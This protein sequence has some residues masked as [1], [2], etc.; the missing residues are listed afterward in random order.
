[1]SFSPETLYFVFLAVIA[2][3]VGYRVIRYGGFRA[4][5][6]GARI[7]RTVGEISGEKKVL[8]KFVL[9]VYVLR[10]DPSAKLVGV[11]L[12]AKSFASY[13]PMRVTL[14]LNQAEQLASMLQNAVRTY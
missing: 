10:R 11:E 8:M 1:M 14:S 7:D 12:V 5:G 3:Y 9:R 2:V 6:F 4:A 13:Q